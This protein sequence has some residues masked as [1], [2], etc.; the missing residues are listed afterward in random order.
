MKHRLDAVLFLIAALSFAALFLAHEDPF[1]RDAVCKSLRFC[2]VLENAKAWNKIAYDLAAGSLVSLVFYVLIVRVPDYQ[3]RRRYK[4]SFAHQY[5]DFRED[6]IGLMLGVADG[7]YAWGDQR[8]LSDQKKF[9]EYFSE[10]VTAD[11]TRWH[12]FLNRLDEHR[13]NQLL[14]RMEQFR[15]E[16]LFVLNN[17][18]IPS[19]KPF[20]FLK[21]LSAAIYTMRDK[22]ID[23]DDIKSLGGFLWQVFAGFDFITGYQKRDIIQDMIN[24][25]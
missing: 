21:R 4:R 8:E 3:R 20:E 11:Q 15:G 2:P 10:W 7:T 16:I 24:A 18:D 25:I 9:K 19:E 1:A 17:V 5:Q 22:T 12:R 13:L 14:A 6:C 23:Y